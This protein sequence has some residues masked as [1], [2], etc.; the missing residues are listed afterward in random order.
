MAISLLK[1]SHEADLGLVSRQRLLSATVEQLPRSAA[2]G[3]RQ[4][5]RFYGV[6]V[7]AQSAE[8][9]EEGI[10][11]AQRPHSFMEPFQQT[12]GVQGGQVYWF[13]LESKQQ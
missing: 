10:G 9:G 4:A 11:G 1:P 2:E 12:A 7:V 13:C 5:P 3:V 6:H 8:G